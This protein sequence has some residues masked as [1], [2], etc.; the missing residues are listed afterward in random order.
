MTNLF[1][2]KNINLFSIPFCLSF[3]PYSFSVY[4]HLLCFSFWWWLPNFISLASSRCFCLPS[5][6]Y[7]WSPSKILRL[8]FLPCCYK[9]SSGGKKKVSTVNK[10]TSKPIEKCCKNLFEPNFWGNTQKQSLNGLRE[11]CGEWQFSSSCSSFRIKGETG[12]YGPTMLCGYFWSQRMSGLPCR[13]LSLSGSLHSPFP[14]T[15]WHL[16]VATHV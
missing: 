10:R 14:S 15:P 16:L 8:S 3:F 12:I 5:L 7:G 9:I 4:L 6:I 11:S 13:P 1:S 2:L